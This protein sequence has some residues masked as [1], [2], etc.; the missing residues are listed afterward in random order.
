MWGVPRP[1][2]GDSG[3]TNLEE[4]QWRGG[5]EDPAPG[6]SPQGQ[7]G[8]GGGPRDMG[9]CGATMA[10]TCLHVPP[11][12]PPTHGE[13]GG[14]P[15]L[16]P[17]PST[18]CGL[19]SLCVPPLTLLTASSSSASALAASEE[20]MP[21]TWGGGGSHNVSMSPPKPHLG[22]PRPTPWGTAKGGAAALGTP[23]SAA[24]PTPGEGLSQAP[25]SP[26]GTGPGS[27]STP[28]DPSTGPPQHPPSSISPAPAPPSP[29]HSPRGLVGLR[30]QC[31][32]FPAQAG[33][34]AG[35]GALHV[36]RVLGGSPLAVPRC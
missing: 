5:G 12:G 10:T 35:L 16:H 1:D 11:P 26:R 33:D 9:T 19:G 2:P 4:T 31:W 6:R 20:G 23:D 29:S 14:G 27:P 13:H 3:N 22:A 32:G 15:Q 34:F 36:G 24:A 8:A 21:P 17:A 25:A 28:R 30:G 18:W 7:A